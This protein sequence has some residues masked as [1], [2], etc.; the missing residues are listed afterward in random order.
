MDEVKTDFERQMV[1]HGYDLYS[2][3]YR[4]E[5]FGILDRETLFDYLYKDKKLHIQ[6]DLAN[7][8]CKITQTILYKVA[9]VERHLCTWVFTS[10]EKAMQCGRSQ[11]EGEENP[12]T[13][14]RR[15]FLHPNRGISERL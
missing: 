12:R 14:Q 1:V 11:F 9:G 6:S 4:Q 5:F 2:T 13:Y 15:K 3:D 7:T 10:E 8:M